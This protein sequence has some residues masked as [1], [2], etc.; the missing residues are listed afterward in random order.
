MHRKHEGRSDYKS[1]HFENKLTSVCL[2]CY[3]I[4]NN[5]KDELSFY[6]FDASNLILNHVENENG[7]LK[8]EPKS[9]AIMGR[10]DW[11]KNLKI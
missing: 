6:K 4:Y 9:V 1:G 3:F 2:F 7:I 5:E 10:G 11:V 8:V